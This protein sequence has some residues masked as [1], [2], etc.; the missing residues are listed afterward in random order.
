MVDS[1]GKL[2]ILYRM[3]YRGF[4]YRIYPTPEQKQALALQFGHARFAYNWGLARRKAHHGTGIPFRAL[5]E[6]MTQLKHTAGYEWLQAADS[7]VLQGKLEDLE[8][9]YEKF[10]SGDAGYPRFK[11]RRDEQTIRYPQ[12]FKF[13]G[14]RIYLPKVGWVHVV[15]H[16][17]L[18][19][20]PK[21][22]TVTKTKSGRY[23]VSV[24][25]EMATDTRQHGVG[26]VGVD[27]G[28]KDFA[29]LSTGEKVVHPQYLRTSERQLQRLQRE[30]SRKRKGSANW[31]KAR[32][33][34]ARKAE[35]V[36]NQRADFQ[37]KLSYRLAR[38]YHT[39]RIE[40]LN[41]AGMLRNRKLAKSIS[42]SGWGLFATMLE[43]KAACCERIPR[44]YPSSKT[45]SQCG[46]V[47]HTLQLHQRSWTCPDCK[48]AH[49]RD[50]NAALNIA[51]APTDGQAGRYTPVES[52]S[53]AKGVVPARNARRSRKP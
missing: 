41:V 44:F 6:Q 14:N 24:L 35:Q 26:V 23:F 13:D 52:V 2:L 49:D 40:N 11:T 42:D 9:A 19:G 20:A 16:R 50:I 48:A 30:L 27:V 5:R 34:L 3:I 45:C 51:L 33:R 36:A 46:Y 32:L 15:V 25:C 47:N 31:E 17:P 7:Q 1:V 38:D 8:E 37:H 29:V 18:Q 12:R 28:L 39:V 22:V 53:D 4:R 43:Y 10:F 21:N